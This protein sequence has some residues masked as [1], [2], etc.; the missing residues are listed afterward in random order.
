MLL[1]EKLKSY[2]LLLASRSPRRRELLTAAGIPFEMASE[3]D[4]EEKYPENL[5][6]NRVALY[7][8]RLKS[9]AYPNPLTHNEILLTADT[10]V[11]LDNRI[12]GKPS[13]RN[14]AIEMLK[15]LSGRS[16]EVIS[17]VTLRN[18]SRERFFSVTT[19]VWFRELRAEEIEYYVDTFR[20][21]DKAGSYGIQEWIGHVGV[22]RISGS[23]FNVMGLP[24]QRLYTELE[25]FV[26]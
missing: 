19:T 3:Y 9:H 25:R 2:R 23:F 8:S 14:E 5:R 24:V 20:P 10:V 1:A 13:S 4:C 21:L 16:H 7:L 15:N 11:V 6:A 22:E 12:L 26:L 18:P 17:G